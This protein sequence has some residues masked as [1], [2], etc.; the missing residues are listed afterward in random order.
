MNPQNQRPRLQVVLA[1]ALFLAVTFAAAFLLTRRNPGPTAEAEPAP[2]AAGLAPATPAPAP[3]PTPATPPLEE[4]WGIEVVGVYRAVGGTSL[5][6]RYRVLDS[7][8]AASMA[9]L[10]GNTFLID[11][12]TKTSLSLP[13]TAKTG[14]LRRSS[15]MLQAGRTYSL[16]FPNPGGRFK[17]GSQLTFVMGSFRAEHLTVQ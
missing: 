16:A 8:K 15:Q 6:L 5:D 14:S 17:S 12:A 10:Q 13:K 11:E 9:E 7:E 1:L 4:E 2:P 3:I